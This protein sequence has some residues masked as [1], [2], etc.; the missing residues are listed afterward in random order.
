MAA[1]C[2]PGL[3][4]ILRWVCGPATTYRW[5]RGGR[6]LLLLLLLIGLPIAVYRA[7]HEGCCDL[8]G[9]RAAGAY[10]LAHGARNP[11]S[12]LSRYWPSTD[13]PWLI[14]ACM[15]MSLAA[16]LW[17]V[18]SALGWLGLLGTISRHAW[19]NADPVLHRQAT[20]IA[21]LLVTPLVVDGMCLGSFHTFMIWFMFAGLSR[22]LGGEEVSG[23]A[24][25]G[26]A[27]WLKLLPFLGVLFL[28]LHRKVKAASVAVLV[29]LALDVVLSVG[30][31]GV[32]GACNEHV[33]WWHRDAA[34]TTHRQLTSIASVDEDR[35]T[36][37]SVAVTLRRL[38][39]SLGSNPGSARERVILLHL[40][41]GQLKAVYT[42]VTAV[43]LLVLIILCRPDGRWPLW[44]E[45]P[46]IVAMIVL[47][48][49][50]FSPVVWSY[51]FAAATPALAILVD[52]CHHRQRLL[53][54]L[55]V[56]WLAPLGLLVFPLARAA[57]ILLWISLALGA[58]L[59]WLPR[60]AVAQPAPGVPSVPD[61]L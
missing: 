39:S 49:L 14:V 34:G 51:H 24:L 26:V 10:V 32:R 27:A 54:L 4:R 48:T 35:L 56:G 33:R 42:V 6:A 8:R 30:A 59:V 38:L 16:S 61:L 7:T 50:W 25:L 11:E 13:V 37:Q 3:H 31:Y 2:R 60:R 57:G 43:M 40:T 41:G 53:A 47:A 23:G 9:F 45:V 58:A 46:A 15:P 52:R 29:A 18:V 17:Y 19:S 12:V 44:G 36:N 1:A 22:A 55:I 21:G 28:L 20:L 5:E